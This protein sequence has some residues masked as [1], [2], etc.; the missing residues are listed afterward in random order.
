MLF[1]PFYFYF[2]IDPRTKEQ[3]PYPQYCAEVHLSQEAAN[4]SRSLYCGKTKNY[5][6]KVP[7]GITDFALIDILFFISHF[8]LTM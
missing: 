6:C 1:K 7:S 4:I 2:S 3:N 8:M 5:L